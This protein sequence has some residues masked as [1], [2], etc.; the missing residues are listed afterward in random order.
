M[1]K[2]EMNVSQICSIFLETV[3]EFEKQETVTVI[4]QTFF[5]KTE[6]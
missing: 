4:K 5:L 3:L 6:K 2:K 1:K